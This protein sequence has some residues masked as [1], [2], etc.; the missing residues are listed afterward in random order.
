MGLQPPPLK[1]RTPPALLVQIETGVLSQTSMAY[2]T[3]SAS[4]L[5]NSLIGTGICRGGWYSGFL[6]KASWSLQQRLRP[7]LHPEKQ[8][9]SLRVSAIN[10]SRG[11][12][13]A[14][15]RSTPPI[16]F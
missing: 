13:R 9:L 3:A 6:A 8:P 4:P 14:R 5:I 7:L 15:F 12:A 10:P 1:K 16:R 11:I 2:I